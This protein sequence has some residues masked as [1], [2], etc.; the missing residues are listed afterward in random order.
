MYK[1][2]RAKL[3]NILSRPVHQNVQNR[4]VLVAHACNSSY[5]GGRDQK[6]CSSKPAWEIVPETLS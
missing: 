5:P 4:L 1:L 6:D 2:L 3:N